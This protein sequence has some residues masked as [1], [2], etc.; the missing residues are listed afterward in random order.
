MNEVRAPQSAV[1]VIDD[2]LSVRNSLANLFRSADLPVEVF[3]SPA[4]FLRSRLSD[5][6][7]C[8]VLDI[9]MP[10]SN[11]L[12]FQSQLRS[13]GIKIPIIFLTAYA[14]IKMSVQAMKAGAVDFITKPYREQDILDAVN[15]A[16][17][18]DRKRRETEMAVL[19]LRTRFATLSKREGEIMS[20][21]TRGLP[22]KEIAIEAGIAETT[23]K[24]H[25]ANVMQKMR[26]R[27]L[28][29]LVKMADTLKI[30]RA[31]SSTD[32]G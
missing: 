6:A 30:R 4:S 7:G 14:D 28:V 18:S 23:V 20:L 8:I 26:A 29:E 27:S 15:A 19:E 13:I 32:R 31:K 1:Y 10:G 3:E 16:L 25:R 11:G 24:I 9:R 17:E 2:D 12:D 22:N 21:V 5:T